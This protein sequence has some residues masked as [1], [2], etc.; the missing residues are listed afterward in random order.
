MT[1][2]S[3]YKERVELIKRNGDTFTLQSEVNGISMIISFE[4]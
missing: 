1:I 4:K 2:I 3:C